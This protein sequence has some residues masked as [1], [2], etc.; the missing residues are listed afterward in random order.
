MTEVQLQDEAW[1]DA[2]EGTEALLDEW[3]VAVGDTV[4]AG[5][6]VATVMV[7]KTK[8][9]VVAPAAGTVAELKLA[10]QDNFARGQAIATIQG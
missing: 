1:A 2:E 6:L 9:E 3:H 4:A 7:A 10:A 5:Q 8:F